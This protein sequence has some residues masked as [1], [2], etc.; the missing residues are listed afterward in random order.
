MD[1]FSRNE[2]GLTAPFHCFENIKALQKWPT[3]LEE[4]YNT[5]IFQLE[6]QEPNYSV[7]DRIIDQEVSRT[8]SPNQKG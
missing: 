2:H 6:L 7:I 4:S 3:V 8:I 5:P 1:M